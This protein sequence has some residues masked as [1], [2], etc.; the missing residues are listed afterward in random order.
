MLSK[1][2][3]HFMLGLA[4]LVLASASH[5]PAL[6]LKRLWKRTPERSRTTQDLEAARTLALGEITGPTG[7]TALK[8]LQKQLASS[9]DL[10]L[11]DAKAARYSFS[12]HSVGGRIDARLTERSGKTVFER[13]YA[14]PG[15][16]ENIKAL[17]DDILFAITGR[18]GLASSQIAFVSDV[19]GTKQIYVCD[20]DGTNVQQVTKHPNGAVSPALS[21]DFLAYTGY[22]TGFPCAM[23]IDMGAGAERRLSST[24]GLNTGIAFAPDGRRVALTMSFVGNPEIFVIDLASSHAVCVT[25][26]VGT[27]C[28]PAWHPDGKRIVFSSNEGEGPQLY[29]VASDTESA[30]QRWP[31]GYSFATDPEWSPEGDQIAFTARVG[32]DFAVVTKPYPN[33]TSKVVQKAG[34]QHPSWS[35]DG[36][37]LTYVQS[38]QLWVHDLKTGK[39]RSIVSGRGEISEPRWMR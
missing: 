21:P 26:S 19:S 31:C 30:A 5:A 32:L 2:R 3:R 7:S 38:G 34:A 14:A 37:S 8:S 20:A 12:G 36:R 13:S 25:E 17:A 16:E 11:L 6:D 39:R 24:P 1:H 15:L 28:N 23:L 22:G 33:G 27:P 29:I 10:R 18:P 9:E 35:P 4:A